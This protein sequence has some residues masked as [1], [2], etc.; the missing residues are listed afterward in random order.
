MD[1]A[2]LP[3]KTVILDRTGENQPTLIDLENTDALS[4]MAAKAVQI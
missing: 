3:Q 2:C 4:G 1:I